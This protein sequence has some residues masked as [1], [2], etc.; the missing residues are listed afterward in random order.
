MTHRWPRVA[1]CALAWMLGCALPAAAQRFGQWWW[2]AEVG[3]AGRSYDNLFDGS[4]STLE[5]TDFKLS[6]ALNGFILHPALGRFR[7][8]TDLLFSEIDGGQLRDSDQVGLSA[9]VEL[10]PRGS[11]PVRLFFDRS[12]FDY[13]TLS[14]EEPFTLLGAPETTTRFGARVRLKSGP[15]KGALVGAEAVDTEFLDPRSNDETQDFQFIDWGRAGKRFQHR[16]RLERRS[17]S[18]GTVD[19]EIDEWTLN[20][21]ERGEIAPSWQW[22]LNGFGFARQLTLADGSRLDSDSFRVSNQVTHP[23]RGRD[24][25]EIQQRLGLFRIGEAS[26]DSQQLAVFYRWRPSDGVEV[27]PFTR[28][29]HQSSRVGSLASPEAGVSASWSHQTSTLGTQLRGRASYGT[30]QRTGE[31]VS[32]DETELTV[33]VGGNLSHGRMRGLRKELELE[34]RR[35][36]LRVEGETFTDLPDLGLARSAL[37]TEDAVRG[38]VT[39]S[40]RWRTRGVEAYGEWN[41]RETANVQAL[42]DFE[43]ETLS[44]NLG[45]FATRFSL[46]ATT[47]QTRV[48]QE[49]LGEAAEQEVSFLSVAGRW[50][51]HRVV[52]LRGSWRTDTRRLPLVADLDGE[53]FEAAARLQFGQIFLEGTYF[54]TTQELFGG[55]QRINRGVTWTVTR[56]FAGWLPIVSSVERRG[57]IR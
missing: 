17:R 54:E 49:V 23:V 24:L 7:L 33:A 55:P 29:T 48:F 38:R 50:R 39:L 13:T 25:F 21:G 19:L 11:F 51:P 43:T 22:Q 14:D 36:E 3:A 31:G 45:F 2:E 10:L 52:S 35:N 32:R 42:G 9:D 18:F 56:R 47:G 20:F 1:C 15:L 44:A 30:L 40:H 26:T 41:R 16:A 8:G 53:R 27:A 28:F 46:R 37:G 5:Q 6:L 4:T 12:Q 34:V 57:V